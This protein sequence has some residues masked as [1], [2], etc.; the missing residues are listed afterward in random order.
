MSYNNSGCLTG[1]GTWTFGYS[2][3]DRLVSAAKTG[4]SASYLYEPT[5]RQSQKTV[6]STK[7][8]YIYS[9]ARIIAEYDG[10]CYSQN[11]SARFRGI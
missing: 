2:V 5:G 1:D 10:T 3:E 6:G 4:V 8:R 7:T 11:K 9:G